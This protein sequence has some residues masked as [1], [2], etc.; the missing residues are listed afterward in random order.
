MFI[1]NSPV[2]IRMAEWKATIRISWKQ[3]IPS[4]TNMHQISHA[5]KTRSACG[6][7]LPAPKSLERPANRTPASHTRKWIKLFG[8]SLICSGTYGRHARSSHLGDGRQFKISC[9]LA[10]QQASRQPYTTATNAANKLVVEPITAD[11][12]RCTEF[13][14]PYGIVYRHADKALW[15]TALLLIMELRPKYVRLRCRMAAHSRPTTPRYSIE[16]G[17]TIPAAV[18][19]GK[20]APVPFRNCN[21]NWS[22]LKY[23]LLGEF[24]APVGGWQAG[25]CILC[26]AALG[27]Y[28]APKNDPIFFLQQTDV[29]MP[30]KYQI[31]LHS[32]MHSSPTIDHDR[33]YIRLGA[34]S[35]TSYKQVIMPCG[36][37]IGDQ[38]LLR[39]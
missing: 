13:T 2:C 24:V 37:Q 32:T 25:T 38:K 22:R 10:R 28:G 17:H 15:K 4:C 26:K 23:V 18:M 36:I 39:W 11:N 12:L 19:T 9:R 20:M 35:H 14:T 7:I 8:R 3:M 33:Y 21:W 34:S 29:K 27:R 30:Q 6:A 5:R 16:Y 31:F 1:C